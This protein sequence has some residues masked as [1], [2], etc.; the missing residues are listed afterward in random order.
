ML[1]KIEKKN[2][3]IDTLYGRATKYNHEKLKGL[4]NTISAKMIMNQNTYFLE[5]YR[6]FCCTFQN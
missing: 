5:N 3:V 4:L 2:N 1:R 6:L